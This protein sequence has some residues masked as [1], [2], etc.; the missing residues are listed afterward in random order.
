MK[1]YLHFQQTP[2]L[3]HDN[4]IKLSVEYFEGLFQDKRTISFGEILCCQVINILAVLYPFSRGFLEY[5]NNNL[6]IY[7][8]VQGN[9][10]I[11]LL[12]SLDDV[13]A[14]AFFLLFLCHR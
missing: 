5:Q 7:G 1:D 13:S 11:H 2:I 4:T 3:F 12:L 10:F 8:K 14:L 9:S 6:F